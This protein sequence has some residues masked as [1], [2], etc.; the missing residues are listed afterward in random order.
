MSFAMAFAMPFQ[1]PFASAGFSMPHPRAD[2]CGACGAGPSV[3]LRKDLSRPAKG[4]AKDIAK[5][6]ANHGFNDWKDQ[7][8]IK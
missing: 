5:G 1:E 2:A 6:F 8:D 4:F 3:A 7:N